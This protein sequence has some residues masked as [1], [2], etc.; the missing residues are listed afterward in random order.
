MRMRIRR[1]PRPTNAF[2]KKVE[3]HVHAVA[4]H[5]TSDNVVR[6]HGKPR[7]TLA[8]AAGITDRLWEVADLMALAEAAD[9]CPAS[10][11]RIG[12]DPRREVI[13]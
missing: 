7:V 6:I 11:G 9:T 4:L 12:S 3:D 1:F 10:A 8:M 13:D 5:T 2:S